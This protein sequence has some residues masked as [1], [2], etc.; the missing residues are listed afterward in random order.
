[1]LKGPIPCQSKIMKRTIEQLT[2]TAIL[3]FSLS[4]AAMAAEELTPEL[5]E[6]E[7]ARAIQD[8]DSEVEV[9]IAA[10]RAFAMQFILE[11]LSDYS[12]DVTSIEFDHG[13]E[14]ELAPGSERLVDLEDGSLLVQR[15]MLVEENR[16]GYLTDMER[17]T[18]DIPIDYSI[19]YYEFTEI[20]DN[21][22]RLRVTAVFRPSTRL[23]S[24]FVRRAFDSSLETEM[25]AA[26]ELIADEY[27]NR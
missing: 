6:S 23:I 5:L 25:T 2:G 24:L 9:R 26:A 4:A 18:T 22:T 27:G 3:F 11:R 1:M 13:A 15:F 16:F 12:E 10:P 8:P 17:S 20:G 7:L 14:G 19:A 21:E